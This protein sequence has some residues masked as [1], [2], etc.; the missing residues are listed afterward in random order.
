MLPQEDAERIIAADQKGAK[1]FAKKGSDAVIRENWE[2]CMVPGNA[3]T[4]FK[5]T[6]ITT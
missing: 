3:A 5:M 4:W 1:S 6:A 2:V